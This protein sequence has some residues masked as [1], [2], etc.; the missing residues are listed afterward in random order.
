[1]HD[2][3]YLKRAWCIDEE[4]YAATMSH[5]CNVTILMP[6][7]EKHS[8]AAIIEEGEVKSSYP[9]LI[10]KGLKY[11]RTISTIKA[12]EGENGPG[13]NALYVVIEDLLMEWF[14]TGTLDIVFLERIASI[15]TP[16]RM[17]PLLS[18]CRKLVSS[19]GSSISMI[20]L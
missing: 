4:V 12:V 8:F 11:I 13:A 20:T 5:E 15:L 6:P 3:G 19:F 1:M 10:L 18:F 16:T 14:K 7:G 9:K 17:F 2:P